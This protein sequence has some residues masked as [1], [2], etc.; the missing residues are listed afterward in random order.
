MYSIITP[1]YNSGIKLEQTILSVQSQRTDL[2]EHLIIDGGSSD[3]TL[4]VIQKF[5]SAAT[6]VANIA[7]ISEPDKGVYDAMNK[8]IA[9]AK[10][11]FILF[12]GAG[13]CLIPGV[14]ESIQPAMP[15]DA[16]SFVYGD[17]QMSDG[18]IYDGCFD[19]AKLVHMNI[20]HQ[21]IFYGRDVFNTVGKFDLKYKI[22]ADYAFNMKC[23]GNRSIHKKYIEKTISTYEGNG[24][25]T[26]V[27]DVKFYRDQTR[28]V[29]K[30]LGWDVAW[31]NIIAHR[32]HDRKVAELQRG[33]A[34]LSNLI[35]YFAH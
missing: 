13:D 8:G 24:L 15:D 2:V 14:L 34:L 3:A 19:K 30:Y 18:H 16:L 26:Q 11:K 27:T 33:Q 25:S 23:F 31:H 22:L 32:I 6:A 20:C 5:S 7:W 28:L 35:S 29:G 1:T 9:L 17:V 4:N 21:A 10:G 12:L